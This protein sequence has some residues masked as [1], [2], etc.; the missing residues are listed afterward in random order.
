[1]PDRFDLNS[2]IYGNSDPVE[3]PTFDGDDSYDYTPEPETATDHSQIS[4]PRPEPAT[5]RKKVKERDMTRGRRES[6]PRTPRIET[7]K[8]EE[9]PRPRAKRQR[10]RFADT[11]TAMFLG[12]VLVIAAAYIL[13]ASISY[14]SSASADQS[15]V[16]GETLGSIARDPSAVKNTTG[17]L[18]ALLSHS[19]ISQWMGIGAFIIIFYVAAIG[20]M[21]LKVWKLSFWK[22]SFKALMSTVALSVIL[23]F[24]TMR[25]PSTIMWGGTHGYTVNRIAM[26]YASIFGA[27]ALA[28]IMAALLAFMF[29]PELKSLWDTGTAFMHRRR[30]RIS[31]HREQHAAPAPQPRTYA[32]ANGG[33]E[34]RQQ[35]ATPKPR[36]EA[37]KEQPATAQP[38][39]APA[40]QQENVAQP[41]ETAGA[42]ETADVPELTIE[43]AEI[44]QA[45]T[46]STDCYDPTADLSRYRFPDIDCLVERLQ[47]TDNVDL[48]EQEENQERI[49]KTLRDYGIEIANIKAT[50]GPTVTLYEIV[51]AEGVRIAKIKRLED[52]IALNLAALGIRIIAPIP[53]RGTI[54]I[55]VPNKEPQVVSM[56]SIIT[57]ADYQQSHMELPMAMGSTIDGKVFMADLCKMPHLLVAGATGMGKSVGL[58]A[59]ICSLLYKKHPAELK[60]VLIDPKMVEFSLY[61]KLERHYLAKL[62]DEEEAIITDPSKVITTLKSL[63]VEM[64]QRYELLK[65]AGLRNIKEYNGR[66]IERRLNPEKGHRYL[67][68]I[69]V[70]VDEF[71]DLIM[72]AGK[73]VET[74]IARIAQKARAV[75]IHMILAT[76][77]PSTNVIT[78]I[79]KANF[80]GRVAFRVTQM[81]D[82][83]TILDRPGANQLIG[84]GDML[85]SRD[86]EISRVQCAFIDTP[87]VEAI[88]EEIDNQIGY[89]H[90]YYLPECLPEES[91]IGSGGPVTDRD[92][93]FE[94]CARLIVNSGNASTS[95]LQRAYSIG[96]NRA[97][98]IMDQLEAAGVVGP[99]QGSKPRNVLMD[100]S[101]LEHYLTGM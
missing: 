81:V 40:P 74:P 69:V 100:P 33:A 31:Q 80:P 68:Y 65:K 98:K 75:G 72:T 41:E 27:A 82:S 79:I 13:I 61:S 63:C 45:E 6:K 42:A 43:K 38:V 101:S 87:E 78:G 49:T 3:L 5:P 24:V 15:L 23:G 19:L 11:R 28:I 76:Q 70:I 73:E 37:L 29:L 16:T 1:M 8:T 97:G 10:V 52:D 36:Q 58:N 56:R 21:L 46:V 96:Y 59:I 83:R 92:P 54:G 89:E 47:K 48:E 90:A 84:R 25:F 60:F 44:E 53:G 94:D 12:I 20:L 39:T 22:F 26:D 57:S 85:F 32:P 66:F 93:L 7:K 86:G 77:R 35:P 64:D 91:A 9:Q 2:H 30:A 88:C 17:P 18:G 95:S 50:V 51:P 71:A 4:E 34:T 67:P 99:S 14:F 62:A 55:E